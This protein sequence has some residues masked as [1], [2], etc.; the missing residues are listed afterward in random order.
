MAERCIRT[1]GVVEEEC[2][3]LEFYTKLNDSDDGTLVLLIIGWLKGEK[4]EGQ[5]R[6]S[7]KS[8]LNAASF[9]PS[10]LDSSRRSPIFLF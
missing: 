8:T 5:Q 9:S 1:G 4:R 3:Q 7:G 10:R 6:G 2:R